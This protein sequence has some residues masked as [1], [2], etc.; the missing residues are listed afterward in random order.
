V[1]WWGILKEKGHFQEPCIDWRMILM[2]AVRGED[3][4]VGTGFVWLKV[5]KIAHTII[6][7]LRVFK[8]AWNLLTD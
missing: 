2:W 4:G 5:R 3:C 7:I 1:F 6:M 8:N